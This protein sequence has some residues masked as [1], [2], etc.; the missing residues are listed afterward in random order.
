MAE[1]R[2]GLDESQEALELTVRYWQRTGVLRK[3]E[4]GPD[5]K[6]KERKEH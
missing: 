3:K 2:E 1:N 6:R 5:G 4:A